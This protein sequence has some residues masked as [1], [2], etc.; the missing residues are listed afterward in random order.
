VKDAIDPKLAPD[1]VRRDVAEILADYFRSLPE[2]EP[3]D[4]LDE[5]A[6]AGEEHLAAG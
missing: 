4:D 6:I 3:G 5:V 1:W 2:A